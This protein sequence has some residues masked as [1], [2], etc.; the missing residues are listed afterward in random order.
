MDKF[1]LITFKDPVLLTSSVFIVITIGMLYWAFSKLKSGAKASGEDTQYEPEEETPETRAGDN[2]GLTEARLQEIASQIGEVN[3]RLSEIE[4]LLKENKPSE[5]TIPG[6]PTAPDMEKFIKRIEA[7][8]EHISSESAAP[9]TD[10]SNLEAKLEG[11]H[12]LLI[13]LTDS[14]STEPK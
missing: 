2:S 3:R 8:L 6:L 14:G 12:K 1:L 10:L 9:G 5:Q 13:I 11:I 4:K 7:R